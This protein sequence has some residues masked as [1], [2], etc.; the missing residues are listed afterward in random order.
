MNDVDGLYEGLGEWGLEYGPVFR[1]VR[2]VWRRGSEVFAEVVLGDDQVGVAGGFGVHPALLDAAVHASVLAEGVRERAEA[3]GGGVR[4]PFSWG[5]VVLGAVGASSLRVR[6][7]PGETA[8]GDVGLS[9]VGVDEAGRLV[10]S[11]RLVTRSVGA[12]QLAA[13][14]AAAAGGGVGDSLFSVGWAAVPAPAAPVV[15]DPGAG[16]VVVLGGEGSWLAAGGVG[17]HADLGSL[18]A[19]VDEGLV[20]PGVVVLDCSAGGGGD[21][22]VVVRGV[23]DRVLGVLQGWLGD[24][25]FAGSCL[26]VVT[27]GALGARPGDGVVGVELAPVWGLVRSAQS[28]NPDRFVLVDV[29]EREASVDGLLAALGG[30]GG[31]GESQLVLRDGE[32]FAPRLT[33]SAS[34]GGDGVASGLDPKGTVLVTGGTGGLGGLVARHLVARHGVGSLV[35]VSRSGPDAEGAVELQAELEG[36]GARVDVVACDVSD[37]AALAA[38]IESVGPEFPL[39]GVVHAAGVLDDGVIESLT[40]ERVDRVIAPKLD[41]AWH[42][43]EL[44]SHLDLRMFVLFSSAAGVV[45]SPGQ[46][47]YAAANM[48]LDALAQHRHAH[49]QPATSIAWGYWDQE[50]A[51]TSGL[52]ESD[53]ARM[54][55]MGVLAIS[56]TEG[57]ELFDIAHAHSDALLLAARLDNTV[58]RAAARAGLLPPLFSGLVRTPATRAAQ[59]GSL[60][61]KLATVPETERESVILDVVRNELAIV[62]GHPPTTTIDPDLAFKDLGVNSLAGVELR[63]RLNTITGLHLPATLVF[64][65]PTITPYRTTSYTHEVVDVRAQSAVVVAATH[66]TD[67]PVA[68][69][70]MGCRYPGGVVVAG[71]A[72]GR[73]VAEGDD[74][75]SAF[76][77]DRG[78]DLEG[79]F[80]P[81]PDQ[82]GNE[83]RCGRAGSVYDAGEF[84]AGFFGIGPREALAMDPQ[85]RLLLEASW[86]AFEDAGIDPVSLRGQPDRSVRRSHVLDYDHR[87][88]ERV[89]SCRGYLGTGVTGERGVGS[90]GV[91]VWV[92]GAGGVGGYGVF[93]VVGGFAFGVSVVAGW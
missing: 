58:L 45:G 34:S 56:P 46:G 48:F 83:L 4:L 85:Q 43:H 42:L 11:G 71:G 19:A 79:L 86:E 12:E 9:L 8:G 20:L 26:V 54:A 82:P 28:E 64:D 92:G 35:L 63:N 47:N 60:A 21:V 5:G 27:R 3:S 91:C 41:A 50:S 6:L 40:P 18:A 77:A 80:D 73:L 81:D 68:I 66:A 37:R 59:T 62:L 90:G 36:L 75:I 2:S 88:R 76:P 74:A 70:G 13:A 17:V 29:D 69:V 93:V 44:T 33:R 49:G 31:V 1:G 23:L 78:W 10:V 72:C 32:W 57:L 53:L 24:E 52:A 15:E 39:T 87:R 51:M 14:A 25:R 55:R 84:D 38:V 89:R 67:E 30:V 16:G 22:P 65:H 7:V 61:R